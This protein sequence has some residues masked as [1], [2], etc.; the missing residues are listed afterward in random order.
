MGDFFMKKDLTISGVYIAAIIG[1]GFASGS[2]VLYYFSRYGKFGFLGIIIASI[3]FGVM[4]FVV[5]D[6]SKI[7]QYANFSEFLNGIFPTNL[8]RILNIVTYLFMF[9]VFSA[10]ISGSGETM[11]DFFKIKKIWGVIFILISISMVLLWD[12]RGF[13]SVNGVLSAFMVAGIFGVCCYLM[14]FREMSAFNL[15]VSWFASGVSYAGYNILTAA[16][17]LPAMAKHTEKPNRVGLVSGV[18]IGL[19]LLSL[20]GIISI[21]YGK[22]PLGSIP[23]LTICKRHGLILALI[24]SVVLY[25]AMFT[26]ALA[27]GFAIL[28]IMKIGRVKSVVIITVLGFFVSGFSFDFFV[29]VIYRVAGFLGIFFILYIL[30][31]KLNLLEKRRKTAKN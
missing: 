28:D 10:M 12:I 24:Y 8:V 23:M 2:E 13:M 19:M 11:A 4:A 6:T 1:A 15:S 18:V 20:W 17:I 5:L 31:K 30:I 26:T 7:C 3:L 27:N 22:I 14:R 29:D 16:A 21:Y 9:I 25:M